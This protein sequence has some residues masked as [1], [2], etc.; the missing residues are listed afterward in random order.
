MATEAEIAELQGQAFIDSI[1]HSMVYLLHHDSAG[2]PASGAAVLVSLGG[3]TY[4]ASALHNFDLKKTGDIEA[5]IRTWN[6]TSFSLRDGGTLQF[7]NRLA[8]PGKLRLDQGAKLAITSEP[9]I[10]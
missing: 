4:L 6:E 1:S 9:L 5:I 3:H 7:H 10:N 8:I 2:K